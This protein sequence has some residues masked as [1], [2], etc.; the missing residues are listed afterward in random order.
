M[1]TAAASRSNQ[2]H[3]AYMPS[4][5]DAARVGF[6]SASQEP[7]FRIIAKNSVSKEMQDLQYKH[8]NR[9]RLSKLAEPLSS[10]HGVLGDKVLSRSKF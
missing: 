2:M 5:F 7:G 1:A 10:T 9:A 6:G 4:K 3:T 8:K